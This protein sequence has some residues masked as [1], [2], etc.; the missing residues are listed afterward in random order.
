M[1]KFKLSDSQKNSIISLESI[2]SIEPQKH[3][4]RI[5]RKNTPL[6]NTPYEKSQNQID[7]FLSTIEEHLSN[8]FLSENSTNAKKQTEVKKQLDKIKNAANKLKHEL[9]ILNH[10]APQLVQ[11]FDYALWQKHVGTSNKYDF[12]IETINTSEIC[13]QISDIAEREKKYLKAKKFDDELEAIYLSWQLWIPENHKKI[14]LTQNHDFIKLCVIVLNDE[15]HV[16]S[17]EII[18]R[19]KRC[20]WWK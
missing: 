19:I 8:C 14:K 13:S 11:E 17:D 2:K 12:E 16:Y 4:V 3:A 7:G 10:D 9:N 18:R 15:N 5:L 20:D 1:E 6:E